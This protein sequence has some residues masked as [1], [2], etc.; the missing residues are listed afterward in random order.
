MEI[1][2]TYCDQLNGKRQIDFADC[3]CKTD[4]GKA[5]PAANSPDGVWLFWLGGNMPDGIWHFSGRRS[6]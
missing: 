2:K 3:I 4:N 6:E 1:R 5:P